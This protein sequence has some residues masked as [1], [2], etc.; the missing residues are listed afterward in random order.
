MCTSG[1]DHTSNIYCYKVMATRTIL[2]LRKEG[3]ESKEAYYI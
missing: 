1:I 3:D 2:C